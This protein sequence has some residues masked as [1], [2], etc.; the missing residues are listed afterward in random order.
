[1]QQVI[2]DRVQKTREQLRDWGTARIDTLQ[3]KRETLLARKDEAVDKLTHRKEEAVD[4]AKERLITT[5]ANVL[6]AAKGLLGWAGEQL[7]PRAEFVTRGEQALEEALV[8]L[9]AGHTAT[10]PIEDYDALSVKK[11]TAAL[12]AGEFG[13]MELRTIEAYETA[14][15]NR[16]TM[17]AELARRLEELETTEDAPTEEAESAAEEAETANEE[18]ASQV[19]L[20]LN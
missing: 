5:Q 19:D 4:T 8:S 9:R 15:K 7:G 10:L 18:P 13:R 3:E 11:V 20:D 6:E 16:K 12:D 14:N 17:L 1:M 2:A